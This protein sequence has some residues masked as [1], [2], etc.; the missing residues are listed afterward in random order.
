MLRRSLL[1]LQFTLV[2][3]LAFAACDDDPKTK[4]NTNNVNNTNN[5]N[6]VNNVNNTNN[7]CANV[8]CGERQSCNPDSG[9]CTCSYDYTLFEG[10]CINSRIIRCIDDNTPENA[11]P[12][13][14]EVEVHWNTDTGW[15]NVPPDT[16]C[17]WTCDLGYAENRD[18]TGCLATP[19]PPLPGFGAL[20]GDCG[21]LDDELTAP[22]PSYHLLVMDFGT[23]VY[24]AGDFDLLTEGGQILALSANAGGSSGWSETFAFEV[25]A[26]CEFA[27]LLKTETQIEYV[28]EPGSI[29][30]I[31]VTIDGLKIGV[32]VV[33]AMTYPRD[34]VPSLANYQ[35]LLARKLED[36]LESSDRVLPGD[37]WVKQILSVMADSDVH[38]AVWRQAWDSL[39]PAITADTI[40]YVTI[41]NG[42]DDPIYTNQI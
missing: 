5:L 30:D 28:P 33:R 18:G 34:T 10:E 36:I 42:A 41:T 35:T 16:Y 1:L 22:T 29:T 21:V 9:L 19:E 13:I 8:S 32:S 37:A 40:L 20:S 26:R 38:E 6:N 17:A 7:L 14:T 15:E 31:L 12:I 25:L 23:D 11:T 27:G 3:V 39:D 24:D 2:L 4:N